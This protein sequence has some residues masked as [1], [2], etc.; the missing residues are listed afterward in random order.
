[1]PFQMFR[2]SVHLWPVVKQTTDWTAVQRL[3]GEGNGARFS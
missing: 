2:R 1:M 3:V